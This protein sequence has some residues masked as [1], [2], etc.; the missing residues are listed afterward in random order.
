MSLIDPVDSELISYHDVSCTLLSRLQHVYF[1]TTRGCLS[2]C[3][4]KGGK[5]M[6]KFGFIKA[7]RGG[8][9]D[10]VKTVQHQG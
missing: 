3:A 4:R 2:L 6:P 10:V 7:S 9:G 8:G 1:Y 5:T